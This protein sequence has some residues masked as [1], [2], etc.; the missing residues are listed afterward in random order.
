MGMYDNINYECTCPVCY[1]KVEEFQSKSGGCLLH[2]LEPLQV[3]NF[4][5]P[6]DSC[7]CWLEFLQTGEN[8]YQR[9]VSGKDDLVIPKHTKTV[10]IT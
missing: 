6:C 3:M 5:G 1:N 9:T 10:A 7:G 2:T 4:Y 8:L